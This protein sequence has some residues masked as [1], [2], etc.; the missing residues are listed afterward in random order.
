MYHVYD[1]QEDLFGSQTLP[2]SLASVSLTV[3]PTTCRQLAVNSL[4]PSTRRQLLQYIFKIHKRS[5]E[6]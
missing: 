3:G 5:I 1:D 4:A 6:L 2:L